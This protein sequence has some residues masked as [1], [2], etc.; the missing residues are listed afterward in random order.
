VLVTGD[1]HLGQMGDPEE[2]D[3]PDP[4]AL[5]VE[6]RGHVLRSE[7]GPLLQPLPGK[8]HLREAEGLDPLRTRGR[9]DVR[10]LG[11]AILAVQVELV[12]TERRH[13]LGHVVGVGAGVVA[14]LGGGAI[15]VAEAAKVGRDHREVL[16][17]QGI[18]LYQ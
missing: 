10:E 14:L 4:H 2:G 3:V 11:A 9:Q 13:Q 1:Q 6:L 18:S 17:E 8:Q 12:M 16:G 5:E 7:E 15:G